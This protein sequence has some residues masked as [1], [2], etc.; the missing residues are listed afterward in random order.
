MLPV[1]G[2]A[3]KNPLRRNMPTPART[4]KKQGY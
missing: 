2:T 1:Y 4:N 3:I